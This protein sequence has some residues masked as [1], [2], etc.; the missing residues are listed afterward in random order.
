MN[1]GFY[2]NREFIFNGST[3]IRTII[4]FFS[5]PFRLRVCVTFDLLVRI[6]PTASAIPIKYKMLQGCTG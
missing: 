4:L 3:S 1:K 6:L 2:G 5:F